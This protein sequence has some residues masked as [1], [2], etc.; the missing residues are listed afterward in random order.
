MQYQEFISEVKQKTNIQSDAMAEKAVRATLQTLSERL[1]G[2]EPNHIASQLP[3]EM[4]SFMKIKKNEIEK[5]NVEDFFKKVSER[6]NTTLGEAKNHS[7]AVVSVLCNA[8]TEGEVKYMMDQLPGEFESLFGKMY[9]K[10]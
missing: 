1:E 9:N 5:F 10:K 2:G 3:E 6:E 4:K 7:Q 8:I